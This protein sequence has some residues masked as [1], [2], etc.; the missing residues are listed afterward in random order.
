MEFAEG[1][2]EELALPK[3]TLSGPAQLW[4]TE[5]SVIWIAKVLQQLGIKLMPLSMLCLACF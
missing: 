3:R 5:L 1:S 2:S 4:Q